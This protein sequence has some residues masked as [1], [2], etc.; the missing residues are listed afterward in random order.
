MIVGGGHARGGRVRPLPDS[1]S[2][3]LDA[4]IVT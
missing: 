4:D 2:S 3:N 1:I